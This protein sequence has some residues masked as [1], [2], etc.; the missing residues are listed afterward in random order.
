ME[1]VEIGVSRQSNISATPTPKEKPLFFYGTSIT[2]G[3]CAN[4]AASDYVST[5]GRLLDTEVINFGFSGSG[6]GEPSVA[7]LIAEVDAQMFVLD[8][9]A[10]APLEDLCERLA[11]FVSI[12]RASH[13]LTPI[14]ILGMPGYNKLIWNKQ[15]QGIIQN[16]SQI[17]LNIYS[18]VRSKGDNNIHFIDGRE[19]L[20]PGIIG[21]Y[22][23]GVHP[24]SH[25]FAIIA[26]RLAPR[27][28]TI[29]KKTDL[30]ICNA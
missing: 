13:P 2:Q 8:H 18:Y 25:G 12:L 11:N 27:L 15:T 1:K 21:A 20:P 29:L 3:G 6:R 22:V 19:L 10:N 24:T 26:E 16:K 17:A 5:I 4:T 30:N 23:D 28:R 14:L 9:L 7:R